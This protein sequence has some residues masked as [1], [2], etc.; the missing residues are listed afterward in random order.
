M[1]KILINLLIL[2]FFVTNGTSQIKVLESSDTTTKKSTEKTTIVFK[3][4]KLLETQ[5]IYLPHFLL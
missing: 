2:I 3:I 5:P 4:T 1:Q